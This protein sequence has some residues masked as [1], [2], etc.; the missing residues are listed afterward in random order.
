[1]DDILVDLFCH[2]LSE[3][4]FLFRLGCVVVRFRSKVMRVFVSH[5]VEVMDLDTFDNFRALNSVSVFKQRLQYS[6]SVVLENK[7]LVFRPDQLNAFIDNRVFL[8]IRD[9]LFPLLDQ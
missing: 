8:G 5:Q 9:L 6:A 1:M 7:L 4:K 3:E 2:K